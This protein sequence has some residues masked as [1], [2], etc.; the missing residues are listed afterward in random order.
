MPKELR[1]G[2]IG[3]GRNRSSG[4]YEEGASPHG[5]LHGPAHLAAREERKISETG[6]YR[7]AARRL[8]A[9]RSQC[10]ARGVPARMRRAGL[11]K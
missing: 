11:T 2:G 8:V 1:V 9:R 7:G 10:L 5:A 4:H 3:N 6:A